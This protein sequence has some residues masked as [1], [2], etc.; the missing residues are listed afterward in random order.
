MRVW[1][2]TPVA[3]WHANSVYIEFDFGLR[4]KREAQSAFARDRN[5][6]SCTLVSLNYCVHSILGFRSHCE[7]NHIDNLNSLKFYHN[8]KCVN[9]EDHTVN[10]F[11]MFCFYVGWC[12]L[13][14]SRTCGTH[15][16]IGHHCE[17]KRIAL[18]FTQPTDISA[19]SVLKLSLDNV[20]NSIGNK[21]DSRKL[22]VFVV[23]HGRLRTQFN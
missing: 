11:P 1:I 22:F 3:T 8:T 10:K 12:S 21:S 9:V 7:N 6:C 14:T 4:G 23:V 2:S 5:S 17:M 20:H 16:T 18:F 15:N 19:E 13:R